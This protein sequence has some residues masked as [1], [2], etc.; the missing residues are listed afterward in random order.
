[1]DK[2]EDDVMEPTDAREVKNSLEPEAAVIGKAAVKEVGRAFDE[3]LD[4]SKVVRNPKADDCAQTGGRL[5]E[6]VQ[7]RI[8]AKEKYAIVSAHGNLEELKP[9]GPRE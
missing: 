9:G 6:D 8:V 5:S 7:R 1:M 4:L 3:G 2:G